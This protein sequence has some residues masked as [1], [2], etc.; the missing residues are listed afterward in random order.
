M[1]CRFIAIEND[2]NYFCRLTHC[3][4]IILII[5]IVKKLYICNYTY[6]FHTLKEV[7]NV[8][9]TTLCFT[10]VNCA[11]L[12]EYTLEVHTYTTHTDTRPN[13]PCPLLPS[14]TAP[15]TVV[16]TM[17]TTV[18]V[19]CVCVCVCTR[20]PYTPAAA[21]TLNSDRFKA[22]DMCGFPMNCFNRKPAFVI[23]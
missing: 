3:I 16:L 19:R 15:S 10:S 7:I 23:K 4:I 1:R 22:A 6:I 17:Y 12:H 8:I 5:V 13:T 14:Y 21:P 2:Y 11:R 20:I 18:A 9:R